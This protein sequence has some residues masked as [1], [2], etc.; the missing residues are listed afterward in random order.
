MGSKTEISWTDSTLNPIL[1]Q[2]PSG[3]LGFHCVQK[4]ASCAA[5]YAEAFNERSLPARGTG[6]PYQKRSE[7]KV[8]IVLHRPTLEQ[9][10]SWRRPRKVFWCSMTDLF[11]EFV[12][13]EMIQECLDVA[14]EAGETRGHIAQFLTKRSERMVEEFRLWGERH[15]R[16]VPECVWPGFSAGDR[17]LF[18]PRWENVKRL[19]QNGLAEG[20]LWCS[21]EPAIGPLV[22]PSRGI[23]ERTAWRTVYDEGLRWLVWGGESGAK[24][25]PFDATWAIAVS[26]FIAAAGIKVWAKQMGKRPRCPLSA[27]EGLPPSD[28]DAVLSLFLGDLCESGEL[29]TENKFID[30]DLGPKGSR[31]YDWWPEFLR[32][33]EFPVE[34]DGGRVNR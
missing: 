3:K 17:K 16:P 24:A 12:P 32:L 23:L 21:Y 27:P 11:G 25:R 14:V 6:L 29:F 34:I 4:D 28:V 9:L 31:D 2:L 13:S 7:D 1:A 19:A 8:K 33:R 30:G 26:R 22:L 5:C 18:F 15:G 20:P 10:M